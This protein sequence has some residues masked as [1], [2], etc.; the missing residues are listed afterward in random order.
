MMGKGRAIVRIHA[1]T[2]AADT[3][4]KSLVDTIY[5]LRL[6]LRTVGARPDIRRLNELDKHRRNQ[7]KLT[8]AT[9]MSDEQQ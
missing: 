1:C 2:V 9:R 7:V 8:S 6:P 5:V 3:L 4:C